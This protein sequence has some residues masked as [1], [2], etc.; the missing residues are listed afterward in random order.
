MTA[1]LARFL[2]NNFK[3]I[4]PDG[5]EIVF[6]D[7]LVILVGKN[8]SGKSN[9]LEGLGLLFGSKNPRYL[10]VEPEVFNDPAKPI[11]VEAEF[12]RLDWGQGVAIGLSETQCGMLTK[13]GKGA[14]A[15]HLTLR[16]T[17][18]AID[19]DG[20]ADEG[21]EVPNEEEPE[22]RQTFEFLL[23]NRNDVK[24]NEEFRK[25]LIKYILVPP[26]R[27]EKEVLSPSGWT[28]Y[29]RLLRDIL[30]DSTDKDQ[31]SALI[32]D[33][34]ARLRDI[35]AAEASTLSKAAK[36][37]AFVDAVSF[38]LTKDGDPIELLRSLSLAVTFAGRTD[39]ISAV[40]TGTQSAVI[41]SVLELCL[42]HKPRRGVRLFVVEEPEL[43]LHPHAQR[44]IARLL[45]EIASETGNQVMITTHSPSLLASADILDV[46]RLD[47]TPSGVTTRHRISPTLPG[48]EK[49]ERVLTE[50]TCEMLFADR[51]VLV[52]GVSEAELFPRLAV[53]STA[54]DPTLAGGF[55]RANVSVVA[56]GGKDHFPVFSGLL[57]QL[58][59]SWR[60][61]VDGDALAG[62][63]LAAY[64]K[65]AGVEGPADPEAARRALLKIGV[66]VLKKGEIEDYYP[67]EALA[68][69]AVCDSGDVAAKIQEHRLSYD[70]PSV[71]EM[72]TVF[73]RDHKAEIT[74]TEDSRV[75]KLVPAWHSKS[76]ES[77][78]KQGAA[79]PR[80]RKT[81]E[82]IESWLGMPKALLAVRVGR[83]FEEDPTRVPGDLRK[84]VSWLTGKSD[85]GDEVKK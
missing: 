46:I 21:A 43:F 31:V 57:D 13:G 42:R 44:H 1:R 37:T 8:N 50:H 69:I 25:A 18:P 45:R 52:E 72:L 34:S 33:A 2:V 38:R 20:A 26:V 12:E 3:S 66:A 41:I 28:A 81:G 62:S 68:A 51:A 82:A 74:A 47:R 54:G 23:A 40:G 83:W 32:R 67:T 35:L 85:P 65:R 6:R 7:R 14:Q 79:A 10:Q 22:P 61:V 76:L 55:D 19:G 75:P 71:H 80:E 5:V 36:S 77:L 15:G 60:I 49:I 70:L 9:L 56:V 29:G 58:G 17:V 64:R 39:D 30:T 73:V 11:I 24:K 16:L 78:R 84:L 53:A 59:I 4:S 63:S 27:A 48:I